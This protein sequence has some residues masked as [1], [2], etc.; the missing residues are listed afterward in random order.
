MLSLDLA[1]H[2]LRPI[3]AT[4]RA[5]ALATGVAVCNKAFFP[6]R[7]QHRHNGVLHYA[8]TKRQRCNWPFQGL[9]HVK[10]VVLADAVS[11]PDQLVLQGD[12]VAFQIKLKLLH[13]TFFVLALAGA[14]IGS[15]QSL[16]TVDFLEQ[17]VVSFCHIVIQKITPRGGRSE[18]SHASATRTACLFN[19]SASGFRPGR[20]M[21]ILLRGV[22]AAA[23]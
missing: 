23:P 2:C 5:T 10:L 18:R 6:E 19:F 14:Q 4:V 7:V 9:V 3:G 11:A 17:V 15:M 21:R 22:L 8:V 1:Q 13:A 12:Q 16:K 20:G